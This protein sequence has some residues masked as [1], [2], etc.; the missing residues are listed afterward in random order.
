MRTR[1]VIRDDNSGK[2]VLEYL[3]QFLGDEIQGFAEEVLYKE[4]Q[5]IMN[6]LVRGCMEWQN[7]GGI[8]TP[9]LV[10]TDTDAYRLESNPMTQFLEERCVV[11]ERLKVTNTEIWEN[12]QDWVRMTG[13]KYPLSRRGFGRR[14][15]AMGFKNPLLRIK[16]T[17]TRIWEGV[18]TQLDP[19]GGGVTL[20]DDEELVN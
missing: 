19:A 6:W 1:I 17:P 5:G 13:E 9:G 16:G 2:K 11:N 3:G 12:Y 20:I 10:Q 18:T 15:L 8:R 7:L 4:A 14:M